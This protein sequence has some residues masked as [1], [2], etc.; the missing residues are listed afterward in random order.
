[1][2][3]SVVIQFTSILQSVQGRRKCTSISRVPAWYNSF[4]SIYFSSMHLCAGRPRA[5]TLCACL[6][7]LVGLHCARQIAPSG[8][9]PDETPPAISDVS[10]AN[11][12]L[13]HPRDKGIQFVFTEWIDVAGAEKSAT[14]FPPLQAGFEVAAS[15]KKLTIAPHTAFAESTTYHIELTSALKD[16]HGN[17]IS[18]PIHLVFST[19]THLDSGRIFGCI[20]N[21]TSSSRVMPK[22]ALYQQ[23]NDSIPDSS[24]FASPDYLVQTDSA[25]RF[26]FANIRQATYRLFAFDDVNNNNRLNPGTEKAYA[27]KRELIVL[28]DEEVG[29]LLLHPVSSDTQKVTVA[30]IKPYSPTVLQATWKRAPSDLVIPFN[31]T[32]RI[33]ALDTTLSAPTLQKYAPINRSTMFLLHLSDTLPA[34]GYRFIY[35]LKKRIKVPWDSLSPV[36]TLRFNAA[37]LP[38]TTAP[39]LSLPSPRGT[40]GLQPDFHLAGSE[41]IAATM[42]SWTVFDTLGDTVRLSIDS[43]Y[44]DTLVM[45]PLRRFMPGRT[46]FLVVPVDSISD[47]SGNHPSAPEDTT[48]LMYRFSTVKA[49]NLCLSISGGAHCLAQSEERW[50]QFK[51]LGAGQPRQVHD[52]SGTFYL[53]SLVA[54]KGTFAWFEDYNGDRLPTP[55]RLFPRRQPEPYFA[56]QDTVEA[57]ARWDIN[58]ITFTDACKRCEMRKPSKKT[59]ADTIP[60]NKDAN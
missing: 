19:G 37:F 21:R 13:N 31:H 56:L 51:P 16:L 6:T 44:A 60:A 12:S 25:G 55:G 20:A 15:G 36:D 5:L 23:E 59:T 24:F 53:D 14:V 27:A 54:G 42:H 28:A 48:V 35:P 47:L 2:L 32:W 17:A 38:D 3:V 40:V 58:G 49:D 43:G 18:T 45:H 8:G 7:V 26:I 10:I 34:G 41:P 4:V 52:S 22:V 9:P 57:R 50:W 33:E 1:M 30:S 39:G 29:P 46:Y 11:A